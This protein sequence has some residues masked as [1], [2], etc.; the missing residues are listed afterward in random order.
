MPL[1]F[2]LQVP[3]DALFIAGVLAFGLLTL[4]RRGAT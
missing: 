1:P 2:D 3:P 4:R